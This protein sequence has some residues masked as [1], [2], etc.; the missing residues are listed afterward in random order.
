MGRD[1][2]EIY[3]GFFQTQ[4]LNFPT[5]ICFRIYENY[6]VVLFFILNDINYIFYINEWSLDYKN[7]TFYTLLIDEL[8]TTVNNLIEMICIGIKDIFKCINTIIKYDNCILSDYLDFHINLNLHGTYEH[9]IHLMACKYL[10]KSNLYK[11]QI[12]S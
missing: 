9:S 10:L 11:I 8:K 3:K 4:I 12:I 6:E 7:N 2:F 5:K 1:V